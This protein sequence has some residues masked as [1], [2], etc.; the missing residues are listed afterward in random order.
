MPHI[1]YHRGESRKFVVRKNNWSTSKVSQHTKGR[2]KK[3][4]G[5]LC[6]FQIVNKST[7][8][9][10]APYCPCC[11][12]AKPGDRSWKQETSRYSRRVIDK[13]LIEEGLR[14]WE[15]DYSSG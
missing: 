11:S 8:G 2:G 6:R 3:F 15:E 12:Y 13:A 9:P 10:Y 5:G 14:E 4:H 7:W 1:N